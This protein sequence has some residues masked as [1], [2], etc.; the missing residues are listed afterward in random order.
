[1]TFGLPGFHYAQEMRDLQN[2]TPPA[3]WERAK[4]LAVHSTLGIREAVDLITWATCEPRP[5]Y[6][7]DPLRILAARIRLSWYERG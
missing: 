7:D 2:L 3:I 1:M 5:G 4:R 6:P